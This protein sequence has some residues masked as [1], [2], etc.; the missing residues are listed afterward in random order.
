M[1][2]GFTMEEEAF[3][4][5]VRQFLRDNP[6]ERFPEDGM[7]AGYGSGAHS[8]DFLRQLAVPG[9][10]SMTWPRQFGGLIPHRCY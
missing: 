9:W 8:H 1:E 6:P 3:R 5:E 7:D 4:E 10:L 2:F